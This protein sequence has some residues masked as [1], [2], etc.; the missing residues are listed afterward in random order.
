MLVMAHSMRDFVFVELADLL[1]IGKLRSWELSNSTRA[2]HRVCP[3]F[4]TREWCVESTVSALEATPWPTTWELSNEILLYEPLFLATPTS[5]LIVFQTDGLLC[6]TLA[7][8]DINKLLPYDYIGAPWTHHREEVGGGTG[9]NGGFSFRNRDTHLRII[10]AHR[11]RGEGPAQQNEDH[12][13]SE[14][15][16]GAGGRLPPLEV[17]SAFAVETLFH[18]R[19]LGFHKPWKFLAAGELARLVEGCPVIEEVRLVVDSE[20]GAMLKPKSCM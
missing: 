8:T 19:P 18:E 15:V 11:A 14:R 9:G 20:M 5:H 16:T 12:F 4:D 6:R 2:L 13:F 17:A 10:E 3:N 7:S 1:R